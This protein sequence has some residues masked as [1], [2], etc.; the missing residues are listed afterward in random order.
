MT[1]DLVFL[2]NP[3]YSD[4]NWM[5]KPDSNGGFGFEN[6]IKSPAHRRRPWQRVLGFDRRQDRGIRF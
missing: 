2:T 6:W 3:A 4:K 1:K 5:L